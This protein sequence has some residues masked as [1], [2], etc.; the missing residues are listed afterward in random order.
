MSS[1]ELLPLLR[2][3]LSRNPE[4]RYHQA[5]ELQWLLYSLNYTDDLAPEEEIAAALEVALEDFSEAEA[6]KKK[7]EKEPATLEEI[8]RALRVVDIA[9]Q[10][11]ALA[12]GC[13]KQAELVLLLLGD[14]VPLDAKLALVSFGDDLGELL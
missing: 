4:Y 11:V 14:T 6:E 2:E 5:W 7:A 13:V 1:T 12:F 9:Q 3:L 10:G 8:N